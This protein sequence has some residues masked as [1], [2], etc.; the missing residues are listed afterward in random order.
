MYPIYRAVKETKDLNVQSFRMDGGHEGLDESA[1]KKRVHIRHF[2]YLGRVST[3][4]DSAKLCVRTDEEEKDGRSI[5]TVQFRPESA[6]FETVA[7]TSQPI[8]SLR[9]PKGPAFA[10]ANDKNADT[11]GIPSSRI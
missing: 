6:G 9:S 4:S 7:S 5:L 10:S 11:L 2:R 1:R 3:Q 8:D